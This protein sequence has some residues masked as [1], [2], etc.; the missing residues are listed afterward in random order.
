MITVDE[1]SGLEP[2][3]NDMRDLKAIREAVVARL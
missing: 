2:A 3:V 1:G